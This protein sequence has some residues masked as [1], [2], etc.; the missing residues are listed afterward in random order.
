MNKKAKLI[1]L[2]LAGISTCAGLLASCKGG[3]F[4]RSGKTEIGIS[5]YNGGHG[6]VWAENLA[7]KFMA[8]N[9]A[10]NEEYEI[11]FYPEKKSEANLIDEMSMPGA[12]TQAVITAANRFQDGILNKNCF[13]DLSD[14]L[15]RKVDGNDTTIQDKIQDYDT[16]KAIYSKKG[17]GLYALPFA[18]SIMGF[19]IDH[20]LFIDNNWYEFATSADGEALTAQGITYTV[21]KNGKLIF[22]SATAQTK[23]ENGDVILSKGKD[24]KYGTYDDGQPVDIAGW[25]SM[26]AKIDAS[27]S[28]CFISSGQASNYTDS[29][30]YALFAQYEGKTGWDAY[31]SYD[32]KGESVSYIN[33]DGV[34]QGVM[35]IENGYRINEIEGI[36]KAYEF[37]YEYMNP[38]AQNNYKSAG[39]MHPSCTASANSHIDAQNYYLTGLGKPGDKNNPQSAILIDGAWWE[40]EASTMF[41][42]LGREDASRDYGKREYRYLLLP[43]LEGQKSD[44]SC[45]ASCETGTML[46]GKDDNKE[47]LQ[48]TKDFI[49]YLLKDESLSYFTGE[50][51]TLMLYDYEI[52][53]E[54]YARLTPFGR[55]VVEIYNDK[56]NIDIYRPRLSCILSPMSYASTRGSTDIMKPKFNGVVGGSALKVV[57]GHSLAEI[58]TGLIGFY[59]QSKWQE[60]IDQVKSN[61]Y[62]I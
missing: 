48:C 43:D 40:Y 59:T 51:G 54:D 15:L 30:L 38:S 9:P 17:E 1:A 19:V 28:K 56:E 60:Y 13:E 32:S 23:Y 49:A 6:T 42:N 10:Y 5:L 39:W 3:G 44:K 12:T 22:T 24:G 61:G 14:I 33:A 50:T 41:A 2:S 8:E 16:W 34:E 4:G 46:V 7:A 27:Q 52:N 36:Y 29:I 53:A 45:F 18:D 31:F 20:Q 26:L 37:M 62:D 11:V 21:H 58:R 57:E 35:T 25:E 55:N 47:R